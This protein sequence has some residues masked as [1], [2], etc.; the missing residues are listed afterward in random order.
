MLETD[1][2]ELLCAER[3]GKVVGFSSLSIQHNF[4]QEGRIA[5]ITTIIV[6]EKSRGQGVGTMLLDEIQETAGSRGCGKIEL[7]SAFHRREAHDFYEKMG[8][9]KRAYFFSKDVAPRKHP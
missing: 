2:Y 7:E 4:W 9:E 6:D 8:F 3:N 1:G 5:Y